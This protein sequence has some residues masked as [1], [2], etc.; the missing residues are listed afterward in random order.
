MSEGSRSF[1]RR[2]LRDARGAVEAA[3][4]LLHHTLE[5][6]A[7][8]GDVHVC[9]PLGS[10]AATI[11]VERGY[12]WHR[13]TGGALG[14]RI[15]AALAAVHAAAPGRAVLVIGDDC[16]GLVEESLVEAATALEHGAQTAVGCA[17]DGG[18]WLLGLA[19]FD[20]RFASSLAATVEWGT[21]RAFVS[22]CRFLKA[23]FPGEPFLVGELTDVDAPEDL[24][25]AVRAAEDPRLK[26]ILQ[27][28]KPGLAPREALD[29]E[30][31]PPGARSPAEALPRP[32]PSR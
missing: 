18:F 11:A 30:W 16:P 29:D 19:S 14:G 15:A 24:A 5:V 26:R 6:A 7:S 32:P 9:A 23:S 4:A 1:A 31:I 12:T 25:E 13:Q 28:V 2:K 17:R 21:A 3:Q 20:P 27:A 8:A 22:L 10:D